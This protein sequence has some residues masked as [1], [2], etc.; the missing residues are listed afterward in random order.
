MARHPG[1]G[2]RWLAAAAAA[3]VLA[4][5]AQ[6][7]A[8]PARSAAAKPRAQAE[9]DKPATMKASS[10]P[11]T[12]LLDYLGRYGDAADGIDPLALAAPTYEETAEPD[13]VPGE[14]P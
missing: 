6:S 12:A 4:A 1:S 14:R 2:K 13:P 7:L 9:K 3:A 11:D 10:A 5:P 8:E